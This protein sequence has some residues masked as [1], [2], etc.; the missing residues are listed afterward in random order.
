MGEEGIFFFAPCHVSKRYFRDIYIYILFNTR[1][2]KNGRQRVN[3]ETLLRYR[4]FEDL[5]EK[6]IGR[7]DM[8]FYK[9]FVK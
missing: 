2:G 7:I 9:N 4:A 3:L 5:W 6:K 8:T 1:R